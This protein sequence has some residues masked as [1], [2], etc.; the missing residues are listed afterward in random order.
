MGCACDDDKRNNACAGEQLDGAATS[1]LCRDRAVGR[2]MVPDAVC[3]RY[4]RWRRRPCSRKVFCEEDRYRDEV[5]PAGRN[6]PLDFVPCQWTCL[7]GRFG[8]RL[9]QGIREPP[10]CAADR[11][12][13]GSP[14]RSPG[15]VITFK[16]IDKFRDRVSKHFGDIGRWQPSIM[17]V[18]C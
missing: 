9:D 3:Q 14:D 1:D 5:W 13:A 4:A 6:D 8:R 12:D 7:I 11:I 2:V 17:R 18:S 16:A 10:E 15:V